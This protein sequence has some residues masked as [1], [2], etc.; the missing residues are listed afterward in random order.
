MTD[1]E[2]IR[3]TRK[4]FEGLFQRVCPNCGRRYETLREYI[5][6][7]KVIN[8]ISESVAREYKAIPVF[9]VDSTLTIAMADPKDIVAIDE[10]RNNLL[11]YCKL[12]TYGMVRIWE[13]LEKIL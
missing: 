9:R 7:T 3:M 6:D 12:D 10:I 5:L 4:H 13:E 2:I 1:D 11:A 8:H